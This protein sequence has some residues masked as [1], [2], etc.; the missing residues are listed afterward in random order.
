MTEITTKEVYE[1][2]QGA[3]IRLKQEISRV[4]DAFLKL[5]EG[6]VTELLQAKVKHEEE[7]K[8]LRDEYKPVKAI[9]YGMVAFILLAVL[10]ALVYLVVKH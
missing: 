10:G 5:E 1:L 9:V 8:R 7:L 4:Y 3:E 6:K 2:V